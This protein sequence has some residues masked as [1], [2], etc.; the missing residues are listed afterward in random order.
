MCLPE[1]AAKISALWADNGVKQTFARR[2]EFWCLDATPYYLNEAERL[3]DTEY[4]PT[5][6]DIIMTRGNR[7]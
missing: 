6:D 3:A 7:V 5:E 1:M 4:E 2:D